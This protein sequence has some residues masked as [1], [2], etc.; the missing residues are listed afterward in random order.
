MFDSFIINIILMIKK[1]EDIYIIIQSLLE[2]YLTKI[3][4]FNMNFWTRSSVIWLILIYLLKANK[5]LY[6]T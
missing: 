5:L 3:V 1:P 6:I 2:Y 4:M